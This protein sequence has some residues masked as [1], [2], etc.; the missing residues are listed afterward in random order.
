MLRILLYV[1]IILIGVYLSK[2]KL[3]PEGVDRRTGKLQTLSLFFLL[4]TMGYKIGTDEAILS[5]LHRIGLESFIIAFFTI[6]GSVLC[7]KIVFKVI[8]KKEVR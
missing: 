7:T 4:G 3:I 1:G 5:N 8:S 6:L 2:K